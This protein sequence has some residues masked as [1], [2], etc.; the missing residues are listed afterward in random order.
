MLAAPL[1]SI[2]DL[3]GIRG[4]HRVDDCATV[5]LQLKTLAWAGARETAT[6]RTCH[7]TRSMTTRYNQRLLAKR[8]TL[9]QLHGLQS[10][11]YHLDGV[12]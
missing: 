7:R 11:L 6:E 4:V 3:A 1:Q 5:D 2:Y 12:S 10:R 9:W 8:S